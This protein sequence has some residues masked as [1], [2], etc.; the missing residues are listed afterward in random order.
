MDLGF[1]SKK[2][3]EEHLI[4]PGSRVCLQA[5]CFLM[6]KEYIAAKAMD[7]RAGIAILEE[8]MQRFKGK[9]LA[10]VVYFVGTVQEEV[11][12]RGAKTSVQRIKPDIAI[13]LDTCAAHDTYGAISGIQE[14]GKG[15]ALRIKDG[16]TLMDPRLVDYLMNLGKEYQIPIYKYVAQG[17]GTDAAELQ[18][19]NGGCA[20][21]TIS[22]PQ[23]YLHSPL[24]VCHLQD[25]RAIADLLEKF[26]LKM[27]QDEYDQY[28][29]YK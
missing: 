22:I 12:T 11:G 7:N 3:V 2:E 19:G 21:V 6:N 23:R 5:D 13:A 24:G 15:A 20:T 4:G 8:V 25:L 18:Y 17:G 16:G 14:L 28:L 9:Q 27:N 10:S 1:K 26:I 29:K